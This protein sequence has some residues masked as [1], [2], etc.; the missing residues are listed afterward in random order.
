MLWVLLYN[1]QRNIHT[2][3]SNKTI[4]CKKVLVRRTAPDIAC[5]GRVT[6]CPVLGEGQYPCPRGTPGP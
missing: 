2:D 4:Q 5:P 6:P 1:K 3:Y